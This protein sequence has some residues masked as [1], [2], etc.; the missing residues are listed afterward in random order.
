M[1]RSGAWRSFAAL[2]VVLQ[3]ALPAVA[4]LA[5]TRLE[6]DAVR[7]RGTHIESATTSSCRRVHPDECALC[8][9]LSRAAAASQSAGL[10][11]IAHHVRPVA[12]SPVPHHATRDLADIAQPRAPPALA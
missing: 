3:F 12:T 7:S 11:A 10:P 1:N 8:Q 4:L 5:D 6:R 9:C 2:W